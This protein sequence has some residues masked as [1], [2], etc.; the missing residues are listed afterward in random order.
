MF[1]SVWLS[2]IF[3]SSLLEGIDGPLFCT[4]SQAHACIHTAPFSIFFFFALSPFSMPLLSY[5]ASLGCLWQWHTVV[6][7]DGLTSGAA[8]PHKGASSFNRYWQGLSLSLWIPATYCIFIFSILSFSAHIPICESFCLP[9]FHI[10]C[11]CHLFTF[12]PFYFLCFDSFFFFCGSTLLVSF[13]VLW[14]HMEV[15][16]SPSLKCLQLT[17]CNITDSFLSTSGFKVIIGGIWDDIIKD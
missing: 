5:S 2:V 3:A 11:A 14:L 6:L 8:V 7:C 10:I 1:P 16:K 17:Q 9:S 4:H 13:C 15:N 12:H